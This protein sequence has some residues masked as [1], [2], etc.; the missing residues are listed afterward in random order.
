[1][2]SIVLVSGRELAYRFNFLFHFVLCFAQG[3]FQPKEYRIVGTGSD[4]SLFRS[5]RRISSA[6]PSSEFK[7]RASFQQGQ[8]HLVG[9]LRFDSG[10]H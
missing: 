8:A 6:L 10:P 3:C 4:L 5:F 1:M 9:K 2:L 7:K